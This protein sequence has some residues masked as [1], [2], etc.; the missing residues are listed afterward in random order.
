VAVRQASNYQKA[1]IRIITIEREF[2]KLKD[3]KIKTIGLGKSDK[4]P[5]AGSVEVLIYPEGTA[6][7]QMPNSSPSNQ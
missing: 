1:M 6:T 3:T 5:E 2:F 7:A 4:V